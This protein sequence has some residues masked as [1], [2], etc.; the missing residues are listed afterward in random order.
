MTDADRSHAAEAAL[1]APT[2]QRLAPYAPIGA[3]ARLSYV[4]ATV[5]LQAAAFIIVTVA[6]LLVLIA[7]RVDITAPGSA[8]TVVIVSLIVQFPLWAALVAFWI[9]SFER[10]SLASAGLRGAQPARRYLIGLA[11][12]FGIALTIGLLSPLVAPEAAAGAAAE[13]AGFDAARVLHP[14]WLFTIGAAAGLLLMQSACEEF[15]FRGWMLSAVVARRG[16]AVGLV[17]VAPTFGFAHVAL[18]ASGLAPGLMGML[19]LTFVG[20]FLCIWALAERSIVGVAGVHGGFNAAL[21]V[22]GMIAAAATNPDAG[23]ID[24]LGSTF[25]DAMSVQGS[26]G[27]K[28][29][30]LQLTVFAVLSALA[31]VLTRKRRAAAG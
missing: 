22:F 10:R 28:G 20:L 25:G 24:A 7:F 13:A 30:L 23:P 31:W 6:V 8:L 1:G 27:I 2:P 5:P 4:W 21:V 18:L 15:A 9:Q 3:G 12:G 11:A 26:E 17:I 14:D 19:A 29:A 16:T